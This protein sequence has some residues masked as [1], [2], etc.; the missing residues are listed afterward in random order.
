ME[1][2]KKKKKSLKKPWIIVAR[3]EVMPISNLAHQRCIIHFFSQPPE[4]D[5]FVNA[6]QG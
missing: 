3:Y 5:I 4:A 6:C 1:L 2:E